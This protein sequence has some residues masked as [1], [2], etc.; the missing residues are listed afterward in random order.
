MPTSPARLRASARLRHPARLRTRT[1]AA[2]A[3]VAFLAIPLAG[4][5]LTDLIGASGSSTPGATS[6]PPTTEKPSTEKP[7][8]GAGSKCQVATET[9]D[10]VISEAQQGA[11]QMIAD[12]LAGNPINPVG[13]ITPVL[14]SLDA[15][16][17][18]ITDPAVLSALGEARTEWDGLASDV[19]ALQMPDLSGLSEGDL[20][21]I[22]DAQTYGSDLSRLVT[23]R[24]PAL[25]ETGARL[26]EACTAP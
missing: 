16:S 3:S 11:P 4:C 14:E 6:T 13:L 8:T 18:S 1:L 24:L 20:S 26:Q 9:I 12:A 17:A 21:A 22:G 23:E 7:S 25:Q 5:S 10:R 15:A 2:A 19:G